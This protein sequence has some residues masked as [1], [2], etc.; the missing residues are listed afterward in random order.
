V[1]CSPT[2]PMQPHELLSAISTILRSRKPSMEAAQKLSRK[3]SSAM[4]PGS[5]ETSTTIPG[6]QPSI[7][8]HI[9]SDRDAPDEPAR[10]ASRMPGYPLLP[11]E[12]DRAAVQ[13]DAGEPGD[14]DHPAGRRLSHT[15]ALGITKCFR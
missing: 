11:G 2:V 8:K 15:R 5:A 10:F 14:G 3:L 6:R 7:D 9:E 13:V 1:R 4:V 12:L